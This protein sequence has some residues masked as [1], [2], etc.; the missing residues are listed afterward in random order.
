[1]K[2][3]LVTGL[4]GVIG[5]EVCVHFAR[6]IGFQ[7]YDVDNKQRAVFIGPLGDTRWNQQRLQHELPG[8]VHHELDME[9]HNL[10][11][12]NNQRNRQS[13]ETAANGLTSD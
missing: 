3:F 7:V 2:T 13:M 8:F 6:E 10:A 5:S 9:Y 12:A 4:S 1:M 11:G